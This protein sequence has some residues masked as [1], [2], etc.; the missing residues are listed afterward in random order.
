[1]T[2]HIVVDPITRIE[3]HL[4]IEAVLDDNNVITDAYSAGT[5]FR[6]VEMILNG[7]DPRDAGLLT[8]RI[9]GVCTGVHY[10]ASIR[11][12]E[13]A[14]GVTIPKNA[15]L[16]RNLLQ[17]SILLR[18]HVVHF[19]QLHALDWVDLLSALKADPK[20]AAAVA[21]EYTADPWNSGEAQ[22]R[23]VQA[24]LTNFANQDSL[25]IFGNAY[26]GNPAYRLS[27]EENLVAVSHYL[28]ALT[29]QRNTGKMAAIF[30]AKDPHSQSTVVG[31]VTCVQDI[32]NPE[33]LGLFGSLLDETS[34]F[35]ETAYLPDVLMV[36]KAYAQEALAGVGAGLRSYLAYGGY[37][38]DDTPLYGAK[39]L[40]PKGL[41][42]G[43]D[44]ST[45]HPFDQAKVAEDV[46]HSWYQGNATLHPYQG[47]TEPH[48]TGLNRNNGVAYLKTDEKYSWLK[49]PVY[50]DNRV[51]VG[52]LAR[53]IVGYAS[54]DTNIR[55]N[56]DAVL[57][58]AGFPINVL[59]S[60]VGRTAAR[61]IET[62]VVA[63]AMKGWLAELQENVAGGDVQTWTPFDF[64]QVSADAQGY[65]LWEANRGSLGHWVRIKDGKIVNYQA[66]V[67]T[68]WNA[69]PRDGKGRMGAYESALKGVRLDKP[70]Q[71][72]EILRTVH[73]FDP[74]LACAVHVVD[75]RGREIGTYQVQPSGGGW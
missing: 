37:E 21:K 31:G 29:V 67:P 58:A 18:D 9:C 64:R 20:K 8:Q 71:P 50:D 13:N 61:M 68:T 69:S 47:V 6:G 28:D 12:V 51:E 63:E 1:M 54:G 16:V 75:A 39:T 53:M 43:G 2:Q 57:A 35:I 62:R 23:A 38:L 14:F 5:M 74:C 24:K 70:D 25:G 34:R 60:T 40:F 56:V 15:R 7:R 19:Y 59:F 73:S 10:Q 55:S 33:R 41:V 42:L 32:E 4:R 26:W 72:L 11:A 17:G 52:P 46:T 22:Y 65:G 27:P 30:G 3:G 36:G 44:L 49:S 48:Y 45:V 66:V